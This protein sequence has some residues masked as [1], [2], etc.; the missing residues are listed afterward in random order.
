MHSLSTDDEGRLYTLHMVRPVITDPVSYLVTRWNPDGSHPESREV[1]MPDVALP[2]VTGIAVTGSGDEVTVSY[3]IDSPVDV[4]GNGIWRGPWGGELTHLN[5]GGLPPAENPEQ[6][7]FLEIGT[8]PDGREAVYFQIHPGVLGILIDGVVTTAAPLSASSVSDEEFAAQ[9]AN[10]GITWASGSEPR[11]PQMIQ[12][13]DAAQA[14]ETGLIFVSAGWDVYQLDAETGQNPVVALSYEDT[15]EFLTYQSR[16]GTD[17]RTYLSGMGHESTQN[18]SW[19]A[20]SVGRTLLASP[21]MS[22]GDGASLTANLC[23]VVPG[24]STTLSVT[25]VSGA[26]EPSW[27]RVAG[28]LPEQIALDAETG[29]LTLTPTKLLPSTMLQVTAKNGVSQA[30]GSPSPI[31]TATVSV[32]KTPVAFGQTTVPKISGEAEPGETLTATVP[33]WTPVA[34]LAL[35]WFRDGK[36]LAG[37]TG[38]TYAVTEQ[39]QGTELTVSATGTADCRIQA[40]TSSAAFLIPDATDPT[41]TPT[42]TEPTPKPTT[43]VPRAGRRRSPP[44]SRSGRDRRGRCGSDLRGRARHR[45]DSRWRDHSDRAVPEALSVATGNWEFPAPRR[46]T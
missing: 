36:P 39:D 43:S 32:T 7:P 35:Q 37:Q 46:F 45:R 19:G 40:L 6:S 38:A 30:A 29:A 24:Q 5:P 10:S 3:R 44:R 42:P 27:F 1:L 26:P 23:A 34:N 13:V 11:R 31:G 9:S 2:L 4:D 8:L 21:T 17:G 41:P 25:E 14:A 16:Q 28:A 20:L 12:G 22:Y 33:A 15:D 18:S